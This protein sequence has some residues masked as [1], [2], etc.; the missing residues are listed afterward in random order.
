VS[1]NVASYPE[2]GGGVVL[3]MLD[4]GYTCCQELNYYIKHDF[5]VVILIKIKIQEEKQ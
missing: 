4:F 2:E 5:G 3:I 1:D